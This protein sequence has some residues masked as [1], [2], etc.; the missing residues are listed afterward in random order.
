MIDTIAPVITPI[1]IS[2]N[3]NMTKNSAII[4]KIADNL[5]G[6]KSYRGTIDGKW[7]LM[8]YEPKKAQLS[9]QFDNLTNGKHTFELTLTDDVGNSSSISIPFIR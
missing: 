7:V 4:V 1:N 6:V 9:H 5:S 8:V 2:E 3:K